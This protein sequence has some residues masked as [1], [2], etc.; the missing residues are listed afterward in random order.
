MVTAQANLRGSCRLEHDSPDADQVG[1]SGVMG[2]VPS[3]S[4]DLCKSQIFTVDCYWE[5]GRLGGDSP[6]RSRIATTVPMAPLMSPVSTQR[7]E[8][9]MTRALRARQMMDSKPPASSDETLEPFG[10]V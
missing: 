6:L 3:D 8:V 2:T 5:I 1:R 9:S 7:F 10:P 4:V